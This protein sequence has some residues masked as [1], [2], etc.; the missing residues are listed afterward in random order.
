MGNCQTIDEATLV[1]QHPGGKVEKMYWPI[2][3]S[4][5]MKMNSGH[6]V[7]LLLLSPPPSTTTTTTS[8]VRITRIKLLRP[9][10]TL[11][12]GHTYRLITTQEVMKELA[13]K[14]AKLKNKQ[15]ESNTV[16]H[17]KIPDTKPT[18]G[19]ENVTRRHSKTATLPN[20]LPIT[21][22]SRQSWQPSLRSISEA[23]GKS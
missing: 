14:H 1:I 15:L 11:I 22:R 23:S 6:C 13:K 21:T 16:N 4:E 3:A 20:S 2:A 12:L 19:L 17:K 8:T 7:A 18:Q 9:T 5:V 10:D